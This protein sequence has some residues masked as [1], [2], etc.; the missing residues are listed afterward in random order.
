MVYHLKD[1][2][3]LQQN[4]TRHSVAKQPT[5]I[6]VVSKSVGGSKGGRKGSLESSHGS[7]TLADSSVV[8]VASTVPQIQSGLSLGEV[9]EVTR[10]LS[11]LSL[12]AKKVLEITSVVRKLLTLVPLLAGLPRLEGIWREGEEERK[13]GDKE[14]TYSDA[15]E[16]SVCSLVNK[17]LSDMRSLCEGDCPNGSVQVFAINGKES[18]VFGVT[19][20]KF[21]ELLN[22][23]QDH[24]CHYLKVSDTCVHCTYTVH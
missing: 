9:P 12:R 22:T 6:G 17:A 3:L 20:D 23:L 11:D 13:R 19:F 4:Y 7:Q 15:I 5:K 18:E 8:G 21:N 1:T 14:Y 16:D 10:S 24:I 2:L